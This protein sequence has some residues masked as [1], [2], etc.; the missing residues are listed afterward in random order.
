MENKAIENSEILERCLYSLI[1]EGAKVLDEGIATRPG[2]IDVV[3]V[4]GYGFPV[5]RGGPMYYADQIGPK[6]IYETMSSLYDIHGELLKPAPLL[7]R[8]AKS[9]ERFQDA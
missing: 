9:G 8:L 4:N 3:W 2:D 7:A 6:R 5:Y 1:N